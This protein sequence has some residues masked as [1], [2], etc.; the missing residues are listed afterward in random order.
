MKIKF[1]KISEFLIYSA[2]I[3]IGISYGQLYLFHISALIFA[4]FFSLRLKKH[5]KEIDFSL[6]FKNLLPFL[7]F[8]V[9]WYLLS[10]AWASDKILALYYLFYLSCG[11]LIVFAFYFSK[12]EKLYRII[13]FIGVI[14]MIEMLIALLESFTAFR[15]PISPYSD[16]VVY[17]QRDMGYNT[18]LS[19]EIIAAIKNTP[20]GF[21]W[22]PNNLATTMMLAIPFFIFHKKTWIR[23]VFTLTAIGIIFL[24]G[25]RGVLIALM[26]MFAFYFSLYIN[27]K[28]KIIVSVITA[29]IILAFFVNAK[30]FE[31]KYSVKQ[32]EVSTTITALNNYLFTNHEEV[33]DTSSI[34]IRQNLVGNG[35]DAFKDSYALGI[36]GGN[37][38]RIQ[39]QA[40]NTH[41]TYSMHNFWIEILVE[42]GI[43]AFIIFV[44]FYILLTIRLIRLFKN[45]KDTNTRYIAKASSLALIGFSVGMISISSA[46]YFF[47]MWIVFG[48]GISLLRTKSVKET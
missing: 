9:L 40:D 26:L 18:S 43:I 44:G 4:V 19:P 32:K 31:N 41:K 22:N 16:L 23:I 1:Q 45:N 2:V 37:S 15:Y 35:I 38:Q 29:C 28:Q 34:A 36:G 17:F 33:N 20:T 21:R 7:L 27:K 14:I 25:S 11:L 39:M 3:G 47:P 48:I 12:P 6:N 46:V 13:K 42:G 24:T 10:I 5:I 30:F 8:F